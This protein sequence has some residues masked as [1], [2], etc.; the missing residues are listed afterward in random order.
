MLM[1]AL[2]LGLVGG[3]TETAVGTVEEFDG[4]SW[5]RV[6]SLSTPRIGLAA[7]AFGPYLFAGRGSQRANRSTPCVVCVV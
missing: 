2:L 1:I 7:A 6:A 3:F 5:Y 4:T